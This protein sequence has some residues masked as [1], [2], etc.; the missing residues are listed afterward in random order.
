[1]NALDY[2]RD[3]FASS[4]CEFRGLNVWQVTD[5]G[6]LTDLYHF[7]LEQ[8]RLG[9]D[10]IF[11]EGKRSS[12]WKN[13][14]YSAAIKNYVEFLVEYRFEEKLDSVCRSHSDGRALSNELIKQ[15]VE[16]I[17][18]LIRCD[19]EKEGKDVEATVKTR[20]NQNYF[21]KM[22]L[23][24]YSHRCCV[25]GLPIPAILRASHIASWAEDK[26]NRLNPSNGLC[27]SATY[28]AAFD[29]HLISFD[30]NYRLLLSPAIETYAGKAYESYF[31]NLAG[32]SMSLPK[33]FLPD[34]ELLRKHRE[35]TMEQKHPCDP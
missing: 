12:Y 3:I 14:F 11:R 30:K 10:G 31:K 28:D 13:R 1:M 15:R 33:H 23:G 24:N 16:N 25:T 29:K 27:L 7:I 5:A 19:I 18:A 8:Q 34:V 4:N 21:R 22:V 20:L 2:L 26:S 35:I 17:D 6:K 32:N 9:T